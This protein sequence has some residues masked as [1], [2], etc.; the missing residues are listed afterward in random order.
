MRGIN[1]AWESS[2]KGLTEASV[3]KDGKKKAGLAR[4]SFHSVS[5]YM[6]L[7]R[8]SP[9]DMRNN[10]PSSVSLHH[11]VLLHVL[12]LQQHDIIFPLELGDILQLSKSSRQPNLSR[13]WSIL[14]T[15]YH[16]SFRI[17]LLCLGWL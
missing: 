3:L 6:V 4:F 1:S 11:P 8:S 7:T 13:P 14:C 17:L 15:F 16:L 12:G 5:K 9:S 2:N 10:F